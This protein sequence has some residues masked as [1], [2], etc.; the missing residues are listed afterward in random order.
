MRILV[1]CEFSGVVRDA[2]RARGHDAWSCDLLPSER[3]GPHYQ[4]DV[5]DLL[6]DGGPTL[7]GCLCHGWAGDSNTA[8]GC[9]RCESRHC[10]SEGWDLL[11][12]HPPCTRLTNSGVRWLHVPPRG[13]TR[14]A[15]WA[16]MEE[17]AAFYMALRAARIPRK[18]L[19]NPIMHRYARERIRPGRRQIVQ[20]WWFGEPAF[21]ATGFELIGLPPLVATNRLTPPK[22]GTADHVAWSRVHREPPGPDRWKNRSRTFPGIARAMADQWGALATPH[23]AGQQ[24][25]EGRTNGVET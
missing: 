12:A 17:A 10:G 8:G 2:F 25:G 3:P 20:P 22:P 11:I 6:Q 14:E 21:K 18:A 13:R 4:G 15:V 19:E 9:A 23:P 24:V 7:C 1:A 5:V 16:D